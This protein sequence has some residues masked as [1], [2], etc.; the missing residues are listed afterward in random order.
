MWL[1][2]PFVEPES[3]DVA[4]MFP[5][6]L[7]RIEGV[8]QDSACGL[9]TLE[10]TEVVATTPQINDDYGSFLLLPKWLFGT[11][12]KAV[13]IDARK[14][15]RGIFA[16]YLN[17]RV[18]RYAILQQIGLGTQ[19]TCEIFVEGSLAPLGHE[20]SRAPTQ[21]GLI[22]V[23][24]RGSAPDWAAPLEDRMQDPGR[25]NPDTEHPAHRPGRYIEF[26]TEAGR[27]FPAPLKA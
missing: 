19:T 11:D 16:V 14:V 1:C 4:V 12:I 26:Q 9:D 5:T 13:V 7:E 27:V 24:P 25:W 10:C 20:D 8:I 2:T 23:L 6:S 18:T 22:Q 17:G 15:D 3:L 21:G